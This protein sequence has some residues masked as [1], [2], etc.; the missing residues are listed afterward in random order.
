MNVVI[1]LKKAI[2]MAD[3]CI[4]VYYKQNR[5]YLTGNSIDF[6]MNYKALGGDITEMT[7]LG[8]DV[9]AMALEEKLKDKEIP[10]RILRRSDKSTGMATMDIING[11]KK[12]LHFEGNAMTEIELSQDDL[13]FVKQFDIVYAER[14]TKV[15]RYI[16]QLK[17]P[18]QIWVY[19]FSKR[20][21]EP[22]NNMILPYLDYAFFSYDKDD[23]YIRTFMQNAWK[24]GAKTIIAMLGENGSLA[25]DGEKFFKKDAEKVPV[26][27]TVG[28]GDSYI[29]AFTYGISLGESIP[30]CM[31][32]GKMRATEIVQQFEPY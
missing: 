7:I 27:N 3:N 15:E 20:L 31:L 24:K 1:K 12:H 29:A 21:E 23:T 16:K 10:L 17:Q 9:F 32:R 6:A 4:D 14:W 5:Y 28:A 30:D 11:D 18:G 13:E 2:A 19:D 26:V 25:Y 8:N 22:S